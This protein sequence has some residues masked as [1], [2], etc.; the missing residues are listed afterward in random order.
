MGSNW[1][2]GNSVWRQENAAYCE[3]G[4]TLEQVAQNGS[5]VSICEVTQ[6]LTG[7]GSE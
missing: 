1:K 7:H 6:N 3:G 2:P 5:R 4:Q